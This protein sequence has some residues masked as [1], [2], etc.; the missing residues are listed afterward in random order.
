MSPEALTGLARQAALALRRDDPRDALEYATEACRNQPGSCA[1]HQLAGMAALFLGATLQAR[2]HFTLACHLAPDAGTAAAAWVGLG[3]VRLDLAEPAL[4]RDAF[5]Q[6]L[7]LRPKLIAARA[8]LAEALYRNMEEEAALTLVR[9]LL[10]VA[11]Q[12]VP[13]LVTYAQLLIVREQYE[14]AGRPLLEALELNPRHIAA[15]LGLARL[16]RILGQEDDAEREV[17]A[18]LDANPDFPAWLTLV[19]LRQ[20]SRN[21]PIIALLERRRTALGRESPR[22]R[23]DCLFALAKVYEDIEDYPRAA[24]CLQEGNTLHRKHSHYDVAR[25]EA[26]MQ[27]IAGFFTAERIEQLGQTAYRS[28]RPVFI[29]SLPRS[30][31]TLVEQMLASHSQVKGGGE[32]N[33]MT[34]IADDLSRRWGTYAGVS[35]SASQQARHDL[36]DAARRYAQATSTLHSTTPLFTDKN[37]GNF[38]YIGLIHLMLPAARIVHVRR[39]PLATA[40]GLYRQLFGYG[41]EYGYDLHDFMRY[42]RAYRE[43]MAHWHKTVPEAYIEVFYETLVTNPECELRRIFDYI[44]LAFEPVCLEFYRLER[45]VSTASITQVRRPLDRRGIERHEHYRELL[46]PVAARLADDIAA[47]EAELAASLAS[48]AK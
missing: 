18:L 30:G 23:E 37:L 25:D 20:V 44:G 17:R 19:Q 14:E 1:N 35:G 24:Q 8:G 13:A 27:R 2:E 36:L 34:L 31:S 45:P 6:A 38:L 28:I 16:K 21:D 41:L 3:R 9:E 48:E 29:T 43:L 7:R 32:L 39:H 46:A 10:A 42:Y 22:V 4:A 15:R 33:Q 47:Y 40:L 5:R 12:N 11:P 26:L